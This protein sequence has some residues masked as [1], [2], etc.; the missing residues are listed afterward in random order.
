MKVSITANAK[1]K[2]EKILR[3]D[4]FDNSLVFVTEFLQNVYRAGGKQLLIHLEGNTL[5]FKDN[6]CGCRVPENIL[7]L[8]YSE[9]EST[10]EG[11]GMGF[12]SLLAIP[13]I[14]LCTVR[15]K[16]WKATI[17]VKELFATGDPQAEVERGLENFKGFEVT[18][19]SPYFHSAA[20]DVYHE[21][22]RVAELQPYDTYFGDQKIRKKDLLS[23]VTGEYTMVFSTRYFKAKLAIS[24]NY[25]NTPEMYYEKRR[26]APLHDFKGVTGIIE[27]GKNTLN[28][29]EPD[30]KAFVY[31]DK[32]DLFAKRLHKCIKELYVE[33]IKQATNDEISK[34]A[35]SASRVL[36]VEDYE[37]YI[38]IDEIV[39]EFQT[40]ER[41]L[42]DELTTKETAIK[43]L[44]Q[45]LQSKQQE[46]QQ[47]LF[48]EEMNAQEQ[49][50]VEELL[51]KVSDEGMEWVATGETEY[52]EPNSPATSHSLSEDLLQQSDKVV[53]HGIVFHKVKVVTKEFVQEDK[54]KQEDILRVP[55]KKKKKKQKSIKAVINRTKKKVWMSADELY[56]YS[57][58]KAKA[59]YYVVKVLIAK[60]IL[61]EMVFKK[62]GVS[63]ILHLEEGVTKLFI[64]KGVELKTKKEE[65]FISLLKPICDYYNL[66]SNTFLIGNLSLY[67]ETKLDGM[68]VDRQIKDNREKL[69]VMGVQEG[70]H[71]ILDRKTLGLKRFNLYG[72][73]IGVHEWK[74]LMSNLLLISHELAH[75][76]YDTI[77]NTVEHFERERQ[78]YE[79]LVSLYFALN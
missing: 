51:N 44:D 25:W 60:N 22:Y 41:Q 46:A 49:E 56:E 10:E 36:E 70:E 77:D 64:K 59:E 42:P 53:V 21:V 47:T 33:F 48:T 1:G 69:E 2:L 79:E 68:V 13:D 35:E 66:P 4:V 16:D 55:V 17:N 5:T 3:G 57:E 26:V 62:N 12:W 29:K 15:T 58:L 52:V 54:E 14:S 18:V 40:E 24:D 32:Y 50:T 71:I 6:G 9:W 34:Y 11:F 61:H 8:D 74:A 39:D 45:F 65:A 72:D 19:E 37:K 73:G 43:R 75:L 20:D 28:L 30:R 38:L 76:L 31:N 7:T 67:I 63:H 27:L 23:T 78:I